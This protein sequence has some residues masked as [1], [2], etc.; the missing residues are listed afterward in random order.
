MNYC[1]L[2]MAQVHCSMEILLLNNS[3]DEAEPTTAFCAF[4]KEGK[5]AG[6]TDFPR[7]HLR[8]ACAH[9]QGCWGVGLPHLNQCENHLGGVL[10]GKH[11][12]SDSAGLGGLSACIS[13][14]Q[15]A[16]AG[17]CGLWATL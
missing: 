16:D 2:L 4:Y 12:G 5:G 3:G 6:G 8:R 11:S 15:P 7:P 10:S 17:A 1:H 14:K 13:D 9:A